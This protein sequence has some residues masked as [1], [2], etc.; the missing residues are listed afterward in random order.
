MIRIT[1][2]AKRRAD[3]RFGLALAIA[4]TSSATAGFITARA[5]AP[6][7][8][9]EIHVT[10]SR[11]N[12]YVTGAGDTLADAMEGESAWPRDWRAVA[13]PGC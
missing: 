8:S 4:I 1:A 2:R 3:I 11:G 13:F 6:A 7:A 10:D 9:C 12:L 5:L